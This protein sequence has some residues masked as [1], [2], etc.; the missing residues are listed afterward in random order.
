MRIDYSFDLETLGTRYDSYILSIG[1][2][3]FDIK[4]G[5]ILGTFHKQV[6]CDDR[7]NI[8]LDTVMWWIGRSESACKAILNRS[9]AIPI[10]MVLNELGSFIPDKENSYVW[11][12]GSSFDIT[13]L[14]HAYSKCNLKQP[15]GFRNVRDMRTIVDVVEGI[16][17]PPR[18]G[19]K[20]FD[21]KSIP[22]QGDRHN[23]L[24]DAEH[25]ARI[26][27]AACIHLI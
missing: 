22:F 2:A 8:D 3:K 19:G 24:H 1:V 6:I 11:G 10:E 15:W 13:L 5:D 16:K 14:D 25:Q 7:F 23:A 9:G 4:T 26:I 12:N 17:G 20:V 18:T 21:K 27:S